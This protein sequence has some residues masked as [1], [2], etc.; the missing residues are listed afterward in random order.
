MKKNPR[1][2]KAAAVGCAVLL[3]LCAPTTM[4]AKDEGT[5]MT[6]SKNSTS[7]LYVGTYTGKGS[8]GIYRFSLS[9]GDGKLVP[10]GLAAEVKNPSFLAV[11]PDKRYLYCINEMSDL[12]G[13]KSGGATSFAV[14]GESLELTQLDQ[15]PSG[16]VGPCYVSVTGDGNAILTANYGSGSVALL[17]AM[18]DGG[19]GDP[20][21][22][23]QHEGSSVDPKRQDGP[24]A[25]CIMSDPSGRYA[26]AVDLGLDQVIAYRLASE[27]TQMDISAPVKNEVHKGAG[28]RHIA[29]HPNGKIAYTSN[30]LDSTVST[31][32]W[33]AEDGKLKEIGH[34]ST[35]PDDTQTTNYPSEVLVH[36]NGKFVYVA[37]RGHDSIAVLK[38]DETSGKL[39]LVATEP[40][41]GEN[42]RGMTLSPGGDFMII[43]NQD[44]ANIA[45]FRI[46]SA[47][48]MT[49]FTSEHK[50]IDRPV[51]IVFLN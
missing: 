34:V 49:K 17:P 35:L 4:Q 38:I 29:F 8:E 7:T 3:S 13:K 1:L 30:E 37:N 9:N 10:E 43:G 25:H 2:L 40:C 12:N 20:V 18:D 15:V 14:D 48:G 42:P 31:W 21:S 45:A 5:T 11:S 36:P 41:R 6:T 47:T 50:G 22:V 19:L 33:S 46:D 28:P 16:G 39:E 51:G 26:L 44:S 27:S 23:S 32:E 24:H